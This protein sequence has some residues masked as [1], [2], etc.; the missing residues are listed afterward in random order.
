MIKWR[1]GSMDGSLWNVR[2]WYYLVLGEM[3]KH[4]YL[5]NWEE[6]ALFKNIAKKYPT[7]QYFLKQPGINILYWFI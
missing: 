3:M 1:P 7:A 2:P 4:H 6:P 5:K